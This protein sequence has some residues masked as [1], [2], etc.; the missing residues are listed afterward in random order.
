M[1]A[2][3]FGA[4]LVMVT[5]S[6]AKN[7]IFVATAGVYQTADHFRLSPDLYKV[8]F[9][10]SSWLLAQEVMAGGVSI[11]MVTKDGGNKWRGDTRYNYSSGCLTPQEPLPGCLEADNYTADKQSGKLP[12]SFL[13]NPTKRTYDFNIAGGM[14]PED[15][16]G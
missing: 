7:A 3:A 16:F 5:T 6:F 15:G 2:L 8:L 13:G 14:L 9:S 11:N 4:G 10:V 1:S 12:S